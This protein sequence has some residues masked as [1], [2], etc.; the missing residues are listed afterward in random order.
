MNLARLLIS[1]WIVMGTSAFS[2]EEW[3]RWPKGSNEFETTIE[4]QPGF[5]VLRWRPANSLRPAKDAPI[6]LG[7][8][9]RSPD[10][11]AEFTV[12]VYYVR[13]LPRE[14]EVRRI[15]LAAGSGEKATKSKST[16]RKVKG[17]QGNYWI[18]DQEI[19]VEGPGYTRY[20]LNRFSTSG[21]PGATS[22]YWEFRVSDESARER[23][24]AMWKRFKESLE[25]GED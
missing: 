16:H 21:L 14:A 13:N 6:L 5:E 22:D 17:E 25:I 19:T 9:L 18:F 2:G 24:A 7:V 1:F 8:R 3:R 12:V 20:I 11:K 4:I 15:P 10:G 23:Y